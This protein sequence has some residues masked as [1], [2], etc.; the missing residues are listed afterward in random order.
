[1]LFFFLA[2]SC[3]QAGDINETGNFTQLNT[4][5]NDADDNV[6]LTA[7][8]E[9]AD[10]DDDVVISKSVKISG[11]GHSLKNSEKSP[12]V[13]NAKNS[14]IVF[15]NVSFK[16]AS[17]GFSNLTSSNLTFIDCSFSFLNNNSNDSICP[18]YAFELQSSGKISTTVK[19]LA[20]SIIGNSKGLDAAKKL[21]KWV[22]KNIVHET[23]EGFYQTPDVTLKR[24]CG[25]C[26]SQ[27]DLF[28]QMCAAI[29]LD[30]E[31]KLSYVHVGSMQ[32]KKRHFFAM[33]DNILV[34]V[35]AVPNSPWGHANIA[36]RD[37]YQITDYPYLPL[38]RKY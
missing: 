9:Y 22:G 8:Y 38:S 27:T 25:N 32:F 29:G 11:D 6:I 33:I 2:V 15:E 31:Y 23:A 7:D 24:K 26:C 13:F 34:D 35:D 3:V 18:G 21:A 28:L 36:N 12:I 20:K 5:I 30:K 14:N 17:F 10:G 37:I 4:L 19:K 16:N 1:M